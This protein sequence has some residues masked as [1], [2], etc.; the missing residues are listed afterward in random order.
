M[1][2]PVVNFFENSFVLGSPHNAGRC[3]D[4]RD[5]TVDVAKRA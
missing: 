1:T 4:S 5:E 2:L 3:Q